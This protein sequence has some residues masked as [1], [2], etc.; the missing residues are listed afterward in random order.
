MDLKQRKLSKSEWDSI[1]IP[2]TSSEIEILQLISQGYHNVGIKINKTNSLFT[3]L[4]IEYNSQNEDF[5]Y[6]KYFSDKV[7]KMVSDYAIDCIK[8]SGKSGTDT[9]VVN[10][11]SIIKLKSADQIRLGRESSLF[12]DINDNADIYEFILYKHLEKMLQEKHKNSEKWMFHYY[13]LTRLIQNNV[14]K[15]NIHIKNIVTTVLATYENDL[16]LLDGI[17]KNA[18]EYI[19]K[20]TQLLRYSDLQLYQHQ[21]EIFT[22]VKRPNPKLILYIAPTGTGKTL[23]P[24]GLSETNKVIFV[25]AARH[26]GLALARAAI[27]IN[28]RVAFAFGCSSADDVRLHYFAAKEYTV[29]KKTGQIRKV[30]NSVGGKVEIMI[31]DIRSYVYAMFYMLAFNPA[32]EIITYWDEPTISL[33]YNSHDL[34][35]II[36]KNWKE[37]IIPN[38]VL[39]S[40]TLPKMHELTQT[41]ADFNNKF[42]NSIV[43]NI[44]SHDCKKT[45]PMINNN[46]YVVMPHYLTDNYDKIQEIGQHCNDNLTLLRYFDLKE[47]SE[48]ILYIEKHNLVKSSAKF[49]R[50]FASINDIDMKSLKT[51]YLKTLTNI[52]P[53][54]WTQIYNYFNV[55]KQ[56]RIRSNN[57]V[58]AKGNKIISKMNSIGPGLSTSSMQGKSIERIRSEQVFTATDPSACSV[59]TD[60]PGS[61][62]VYITTKDAH[63]L[64]DGPTIFLANDVH[65]IS[66][67]CIQ[68]SNIPVSVMKDIMEKIEYNN[69]IN[70]RISQIEDNMVLQEE[71]IANKIA[72]GSSDKKNKKIAEK[73]ISKTQDKSI[74]Q[75]REELDTLKGMVKS[76]RLNDLFIPNTLTH[77]NKWAEGLNAK[78]TFTS[79]IDEDIVSSIMLL[80]DVHDSWK[81]LLL[82]GIG[83][84]TEHKSSSYTEIMKK[85]A[86]Q[87]K[88]YLIIADSDYIYGT[89]YQFCHG[90]LSKDMKLTQEKIIQA[91][92]R[93]G[94]NNIQQEYSIRF[95]DDEQINTL[96]TK[97]ASEEKPEVINMNL[98]FNSKQV[99]WD[100]ENY[101]EQ[102]EDDESNYNDEE[103][104]EEDDEEHDY[105]LEDISGSGNE[106]VD[107]DVDIDDE[108]L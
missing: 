63:T 79:N 77:L 80:K 108:V 102:D 71:K 76:A 25:C 74:L 78:N 95:R 24:L 107:I 55:N 8:F 29:N 7:K 43:V 105:E 54:H 52:I 75:M 58:D 36:K 65:K 41:I 98:L 39:S 94:R 3:F 32:H 6:N 53:Q 67:F 44:L 64:T 38:V 13:T 86:D 23:T 51:H 2:V 16:Q 99:H 68:Q 18:S 60:V 87:Q 101:I 17:V 47:A 31:C 22:Q 61:C 88:L 56:K 10:V 90:Y 28:K 103:D 70:E 104:D 37:N 30:D 35:H 20:N 59:T 42:Y 57:T 72:S 84:F 96:F 83:V 92:G 45:I 85:L 5:L 81:I 40:A 46:G 15:V 49:D 19:E 82:L 100:G 97:F 69:R 66:K 12:S 50:N 62:G 89:N 93:I 48:F 21:K 11:S 34:H 9:Y 27:S 1:E 33:D 91:M 106:D 4:K 14:E 73:L 26:V